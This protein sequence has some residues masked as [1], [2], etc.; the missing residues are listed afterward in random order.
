MRKLMFVAL[1]AAL[2]WPAGAQATFPGAN[3]KIAFQRGYDI[4]TMNPDGSDQVNLTNTGASGYSPSWSADGTKIVFNGPPFGNSGQ[5]IWYMNADGSGLT[6][7]GNGV[8]PDQS[9][10]WSPDSSQIAFRLQNSFYVMPPDNSSRTLLGGFGLANELDWSPDGQAIAIDLH[11]GTH[12]FRSGTSGYIGTIQ[13]V[14]GTSVTP[15]SQ[16][17]VCTD[18]PT[19]PYWD[20]EPSWSPDS[21]RIAF[22]RANAP[23]QHTPI[24]LFS[25]RRDGTDLETVRLDANAS[26][27]VWSPDGQKIAFVEGDYQNG[28]IQVMN[29]DNTGLVDVTDGFQPSWQPIP[30]N[31]YPRPKGATPLR[32]SLVPANQECTSPNNTH[33]APLSYASCSPVQLSSQYLTT[34]TPD[35]SNG[36]GA[37]MTAALLLKTIVGNPMTPGD[38]ADLKI[39]ALV[40][41]VRNKDLSDYTGSLHAALPLQITDRDNTPTPSGPGAGTTEALSYG[42]DV[43]CT[44][45]VD[46]LTGSTCLLATTADTLVPGVI[47]EGARSIWEIGQAQVFDG[48]ADE[49]G[50]TSADNTLFATEG[51]FVP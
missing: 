33:G 27:P 37:H 22:V 11:C 4:W 2:V 44:A 39:D 14:A 18:P 28:R 30:V 49:D 42:F 15:V 6:H 24:G 20:R 45:T 43:P 31:T 35:S 40:N 3:G 16:P 32:I 50:S 29:A 9:P 7:A 10:G 1:L 8:T 21:Q 41:D 38:Q 13:P 47:K 19:Q 5:Q 34:G 12:P 23:L 25:V 17:T 46:T 48:G 26:D 36:L 51:V